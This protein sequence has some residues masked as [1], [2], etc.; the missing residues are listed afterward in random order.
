MLGIVPT[1]EIT[2]VDYILKFF[3][4]VGLISLGRSLLYLLRAIF[5]M[6]W[7][8]PNLTKRYGDGSWAVVTGASDGIG[9]G[10]CE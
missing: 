1:T 5:R 2:P 4:A 8:A 6:I 9:R 10:F 3:M 7:P